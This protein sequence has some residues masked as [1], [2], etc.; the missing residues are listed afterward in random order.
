MVFIFSRKFSESISHFIRKKYKQKKR[1]TAKKLFIAC[2]ELSINWHIKWEKKKGREKGNSFSLTK[3]TGGFLIIRK[4]Y[5]PSCVVAYPPLPYII[6]VP[7]ET[8]IC[9]QSKSLII[10][11]L[12]KE[13]EKERKVWYWAMMHACG[14]LQSIPLKHHWVPN[15]PLL[16]TLIACTNTRTSL[17]P[18]INYAILCHIYILFYC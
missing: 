2:V 9:H 15:S 17:E 3:W 8:K 11:K 1:K 7:H 12:K 6:Q 14:F 18:W 13:K 5:Y 10:K 4:W 16:A